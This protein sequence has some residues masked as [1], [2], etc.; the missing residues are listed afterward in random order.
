MIAFKASFPKGYSSVLIPGQ[1][2]QY[3]FEFCLHCHL[4]IGLLGIGLQCPLHCNCT[5]R[6]MSCAVTEYCSNQGCTEGTIVV[7]ELQD[8]PL[9]RGPSPC[10]WQHTELL[11]RGKLDL[12]TCFSSGT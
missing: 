12:T 5:Q 2:S 1:I 10:F 8:R 7:S 11:L 4:S 9:A 3:H 6:A